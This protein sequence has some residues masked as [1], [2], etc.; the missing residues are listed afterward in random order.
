MD[1]DERSVTK[2]AM[3]ERCSDYTAHAVVQYNN[4]TTAFTVYVR[5]KNL[6][7][8][9]FGSMGVISVG[10]PERRA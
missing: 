7:H 3:L 8:F 5:I 2:V 10:R 9:L 4:S 6:P 1:P